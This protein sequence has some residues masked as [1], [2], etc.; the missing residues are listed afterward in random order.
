LVPP[1]RG[2]LIDVP[3]ASFVMGDPKGDPNEA[4]RRVTVGPFRIMRFEVTNAQWAAFVAATG[5]VT[6]P[7]KR[8]FGMVWPGR[9]VRSAGADWRH[10]FGPGSSVRG[11]DDHPVVQ[12][13]ARDAAA[14]CKHHGMRLPTEAEW[15]LAARGTDGRRFPW[16]DRPP[17]RTGPV[18][19]RRGNFGVRPCCAADPSDGYAKT[20]PVG[21]YPRGV[22]PYG[23][24]D[25]AGNVWEWTASEF[26]GRPG[27]VALRGGGWGNNDYCLRVSYR[28]ANV[29]DI[30]RDHIGF[31]CAADARSSSRPAR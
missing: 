9:W 16:G 15:E 4:P 20:A 3:G 29:P 11:R 14:F 18:S 24:Y 30:G 10:P 23:L 1:P 2:Q 19:R 12:I 21:S 8:G 31:R 27:M 6:D 26:P 7:E 13:S 5:H 25:M 17:A 28:H 22:S